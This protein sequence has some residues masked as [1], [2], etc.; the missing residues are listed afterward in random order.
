MRRLTRTD[1]SGTTANLS[2]TFDSMGRLNTMTDNIA[3]EQIIQ[4]ASYGPANELLSITG[5]NY[6]GARAGE[7]RSYNSLKQVT[8]LAAGT[9]GVS[10][11][12]PSTGNNGKISSQTDTVSGETVTYTYDSLNRLATAATQSNFNP[13]WGQSF[14]YDGF[15]NLTNVAVT[16][17]SAPTFSAGYD[18]NNH[19]G[20]EDANGNPGSVPMPA[21]GTSAAPTWDV[22][23]RLTALNGSTTSPVMY[24]SYA[25]GNKRVWRG[26]WTYN[27]GTQTWSRGSTD[28]VTFWSIN[29]QKMATYQLTLS[30]SF[31]ATQTGINY[32]FGGKLI[33][34]ANGWVY[35]DRLASIG[36]FYP[37]GIERPSATQNGT[38]KF[39]GYFRDAET[40]NDYA[41]QRYSSPGMGR[42]MTPDRMTGN[43]SNPGSWNKY[44][45]ASGDPINRK[46]PGGNYDCTVGV[47]EYE[48]VT[49][50]EDFT[51]FQGPANPQCFLLLQA[52]SGNPGNPVAAQL[53]E[54]E[55]GGGVTMAAGTSAPTS[56]MNVQSLA[57]NAIFGMLATALAGTDCGAWLQAGV[58][59][60]FPN[61]SLATFLTDLLPTLVAS[62]TFVGG[63]S[64]AVTGNST[65]GMVSP[66]EIYINAALGFF[67]ALPPGTSLLIADSSSIQQQINAIN[68]GSP[69]AQAFILLHEVAHLLG[70][71][72]PDAGPGNSQNQGSNNNLIWAA[73]SSVIQGF[74]N[75]GPSQ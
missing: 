19:A 29:G 48:E 55:C 50:C 25:P 67:N 54:T 23:N 10:Y 21:Y 71:I 63:N 75:K 13:S 47:G 70:M 2:Y 42:F 61:V 46:D 73:C 14:T 7:A 40:G 12:Y 74:S 39:T 38:E 15:G 58:T 32:Y 45:Y 53:F 16:Q 9:V 34:N 59:A 30:G 8:G 31:T 37:Y 57:G 69:E 28:E 51:V 5:G 26:N 56:V 36:K 27:S 3:N 22:E 62:A 64:E 44:A 68:G 52:A 41:D 17:G 11:A 35:S 65:P 60:N 33:K 1:N 49:E 72:Q 66:Y 43:P 24:Y 6:L 20:G 18:V 4:G